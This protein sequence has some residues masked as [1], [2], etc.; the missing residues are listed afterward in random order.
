MIHYYLFLYVYTS[1]HI[2]VMLCK[3]FKSIHDFEYETDSEVHYQDLVRFSPTYISKLRLQEA[4]Y[5]QVEGEEDSL[6]PPCDQYE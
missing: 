3:S 5:R 1:E 2:Y 6:L 4:Y